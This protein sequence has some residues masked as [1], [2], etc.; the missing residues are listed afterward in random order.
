MITKKKRR[1]I[2]IIA[3]LAVILVIGIMFLVLYLTTDLFKSSQTLFVKYIGNNVDNLKSLE[4]IL[5]DT[6]YDEQL[7]TNP[8][9]I[10][11]QANVI[12]TE[13]VGTTDENV[14]NSVNQLKFSVEGQTDNNSQYDYRNMKLLKGNEQVAQVE[15][16][17]S[18]SDY[19]IKFTDLF[20]QYLVSENTNL[21]ELFRKMG[22][23]EE[24]IQNIPD[25][26]TLDS[27]IL[28]KMKFT[29]DELAT[30][31]EKY[32][33]IISQN[34]S[35]ENFSKQTKQNI[36]INGQNYVANAYILTLTKEQL[37]DIYINL[38]ENIEQD[39]II[40]AKFDV[41]QNKL[42][43]ITLGNIDFNVRDNIVNKIDI[44]INKIKQNN[45]G[46]DETRIIVYEN[47]GNTL[48]T[49]VETEEYQTN[50]DFLQ[51]NERSY[52]ELLITNEDEEKYRITLDYNNNNLSI[53][54]QDSDKG[55]KLLVKKEQQVNNLSRNQNYSIEYQVDDKKVEVSLI[56]DI[57]IIESLEE[58]KNFDSEGKVNL[59]ELNDDQ[60]KEIMNTVRNGLNSEVES[61][62]EKIV[63]QD[64]ENMLIGIE[65]MKD[66]TVLD[67]NGITETE[68]NRFNYNFE[69]LQG[70]GLEAKSVKNAIQ[71][72]KDNIES[73]EI[74]SGSE[75]RLNIVRGQGNE[76]VVNTLTAFLDKSV[77]NKYNISVN[78]DENGLVNQLILKIEEN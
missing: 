37:N 50:I 68:K 74:I 61:V 15:Y 69:L 20:N 22:Y 1:L 75:L 11:M 55:I 44:T 60:L 25:S 10:N 8:Y 71:V 35:S 73:M 31:S 47:N 4:S 49:R 36:T 30:L 45:I 23:T 59:N 70:E 24:E 63:Y 66:S 3:I 65:L 26:V 28:D 33:G 48:R 27:E 32:I 46:A 34:V 62:K 51:S 39:E 76:E 58:I 57:D 12:Y 21:K 52:E 14:N 40:L 7:K 67:S 43:E 17:H 2:L 41:L 56:E 9:N 64:I 78:Y 18:S 19:G 6:E 38:L 54:V 5:D 13:N 42:N 77:N 53:Y 72:I 29:D 16:L